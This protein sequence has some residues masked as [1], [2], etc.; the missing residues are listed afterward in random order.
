MVAH[1]EGQAEGKRE[2][3]MRTLVISDLHLGNGGKYDAFAAEDELPLFLDRHAK[4][5]THVFVNGDSVDFL[6]NEDPLE[7]D[8]ARAAQQAKDIVANPATAGV[9]RAFGGVLAR[10]GAVT[11][12][13][14]NHDLELSLP[15]VQDVIARALGQPAD[16]AGRLEFQLGAEPKRLDVG[17]AK[18]L[19]THGEHNDGWNKVDYAQLVK[20]PEKYVYTAGSRLVKQ[21]MNPLTRELGMRF[22]NFLKPDFQGGALTGLAVNATMVKA[23]FK[24]ASLDIGWQLFKRIGSLPSFDDDGTGAGANLGLSDRIGAAGLSAEEQ[25]ELESLMG[26]EGGVASFADDGEV[27][28]WSVKIARAA[29]SA[30]A[31][32]QRK[33]AGTTGDTFFD[34][35][36][37]KGEWED[38]GRLAKKYSTGAVVYGHT[39]AARWREAEGVVFA[40]TGTWIW[41]MQLP[42]SRESDATWA[43]FINE[44][45]SNPTLD[46]ARQKIAKTRKRLTAVSLEP[47]ASGGASMSLV[48]WDGDKIEVLGETRVAPASA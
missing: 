5:P 46:R 20:A 25:A 41:L 28:T 30:Y 44:L 13:L 10:G 45:R 22:M 8:R 1:P 36:P 43:D 48:A 34:L 3:R 15:E 40:N 18:I 31:G 26:D 9:L 19:V 33:V 6:M 7:M 23:L 2:T 38:A 35:T 39:H 17:G 37:D 11:I 27:S 12:R 32:F 16:V 29:L 21:V 4:E 24:K 14:G 47:H 42:D